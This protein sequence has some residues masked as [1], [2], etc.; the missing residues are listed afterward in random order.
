MNFAG[1]VNEE[2]NY[3]WSRPERTSERPEVDIGQL[4]RD[5][6]YRR[7]R[8][9]SEGVELSRQVFRT[10]G[11]RYQRAEGYTIAYQVVK[12]VVQ[13]KT[14]GLTD[15]PTLQQER[16]RKMCESAIKEMYA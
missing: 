6:E 11:D 15:I 16:W 8:K 14:I 10:G 3:S 2:K 12:Q 13:T 4:L 1:R 9:D 5:L 7:N